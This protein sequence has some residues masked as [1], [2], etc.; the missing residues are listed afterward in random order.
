MCQINAFKV[1]PL[2]ND[3]E[4]LT[5]TLAFVSL[6]PSAVK[7]SYFTKA[8]ASTQMCHNVV[9]VSAYFIRSL[10]YIIILDFFPRNLV[11]VLSGHIFEFR[12]FTRVV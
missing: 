5:S 10:R 4:D 3:F 9:A 8:S 11:R 7:K 6:V 1:F 12:R 2:T